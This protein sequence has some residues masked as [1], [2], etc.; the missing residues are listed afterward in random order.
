MRKSTYTMRPLLA[1]TDSGVYFLTALS[2][3]L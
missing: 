3:P 2:V 1:D